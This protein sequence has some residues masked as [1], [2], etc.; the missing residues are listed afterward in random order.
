MKNDEKARTSPITKATPLNTATL[1]ANT[2]IR[3]GTAPKVA[4][5]VPVLYSALTTR[6]PSTPMAS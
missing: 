1:A 4:L 5:M 3:W 2:V 6:T